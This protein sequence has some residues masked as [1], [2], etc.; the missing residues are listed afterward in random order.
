MRKFNEDL[1]LAI[2]AETTQKYDKRKRE[3]L[4]PVLEP[5]LLEQLLQYEKDGPGV[6][7][8]KSKEI[9][10]SHVSYG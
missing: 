2:A 1:N 7:L 3:V 5:S 10:W 4:L 8:R 9:V 6:C